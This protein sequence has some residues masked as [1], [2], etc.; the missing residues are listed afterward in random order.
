MGEIRLSYTSGNF[1][2]ARPHQ[3]PAKCTENALIVRIGLLSLISRRRDRGTGGDRTTRGSGSGLGMNGAGE[4]NGTGDTDRSDVG[5][6]S[7]S[8]PARDT[9]AVSTS[10]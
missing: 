3:R 2:C 4:P 9:V 5:A 10:L 8:L 7:P 1:F 6:S